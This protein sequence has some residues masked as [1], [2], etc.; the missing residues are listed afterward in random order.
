MYN[1]ENVKG[2]CASHHPNVEGEPVEN[3]DKLD[4]IYAETRY[5]SWMKS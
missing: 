5:P 4:T 2:V 1:F 3:L